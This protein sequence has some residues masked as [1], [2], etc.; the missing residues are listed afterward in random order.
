MLVEQAENPPMI[1]AAQRSTFFRQSGWLMIAN[2]AGGMF[3]WAVHFLNRFIHTGEYGRFGFFLAVVMLVPTIPL[4]MV[5]AQ[6][7]ARALASNREHE[8]SGVIRMIWLV[9]SG[10]WLVLAIV[11]L[12]FQKQILA[13]YSL[14]DPYGLW[15]TLPI[16][17]LT[18]WMPLFWGVL[19]GQQNFLWLGWSMMVNGIGRLGVGALAVIVLGAGAAGMMAGVLL[20]IVA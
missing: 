18:L 10:V 7:T 1:Q 12:L 8:L 9:T 11:V 20:G 5:L 3:M 13:R 6:Q 19:Q 15:I 17:L 2:I 4:Q 14:S 16:V